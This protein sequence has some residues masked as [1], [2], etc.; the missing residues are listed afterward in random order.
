MIISDTHNLVFQPVERT[1][2]QTIESLLLSADPNSRW[3][4]NFRHERVAV[5][6]G[7]SLL[8]SRRDS[9]ER[10]ISWWS[11]AVTIDY[12][13]SPLWTTFESFLSLMV[14]NL[15]QPFLHDPQSSLYAPHQKLINDLLVRC[16]IPQSY[17]W[18]GVTPAY[19]VEY[20]TFEADVRGLPFV[21]VGAAVPVVDSTNWELS[22]VQF[23]GMAALANLYDWGV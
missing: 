9:V 11:K 12:M 5:P 16:P 23:D 7:Y 20:A 3:L 14:A 8:I 1:G 6:V 10:L 21:P 15:N 4:G 22:D 18:E 17:Y 13:G 2:S 19:T